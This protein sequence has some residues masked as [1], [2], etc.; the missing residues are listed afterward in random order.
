[1][2]RA[3]GTARRVGIALG[4]TALAVGAA[5]LVRTPQLVE[6]VAQGESRELRPDAEQV[7]RPAPGEGTDLLV[8]ALDGIGRQVL[9]DA[10]RAGELPELAALLGG[11]DGRDLPHAHLHP[12]L[13]SVLPSSTIP[14]WASIFS[15]A[16]PGEHGVVGNEFFLREKRELAAPAPASI[17]DIS[18]ALAIY[19]DAGADQWLHGH[20]VYERLRL[21]EPG[22]R[23]WV[24]LSQFYRGA[25]RL[26]LARRTAIAS[27]LEAYLI[28]TAW[29]EGSE[30]LFATL[31]EEVV[32]TVV[33]ELEERDPPN[34]LTV[35]L[36]GADLFA[37]RS[38]EGPD[39]IP[40]YLREPLDRI[41]GQ[42]RRALDARGA[43]ADRWVVVVSDHGHTEVLEDEHH[44]LGADPDTG[45][46]AVLAGAG[47]R[48][49]PFEWKV[50]DD[51]PFDAVLAYQG[52]MAFV[53]VADRS[54]CGG[55]PC[56]WT[57]PPR[58]EEDVVPVA[59]AFLRATERGEL[60]P[61]LRG[62]IAL[63]LAR[64]PVPPEGPPEPFQVYVGGGRLVPVEEHLTRSPQPGYV[65]LAP[66]LRDL[67]VGPRG[68]RAGDV[69]LIASGTH[70]DDIG[71]R[72]YFSSEY[73][74]WHGS[75]S[76]LDSEVP[77]I[78][79]HPRGSAGEIAAIVRDVLGGDPTQQAVG[80][81]LV[82]L[83]RESV[84]RA[85]TNVRTGR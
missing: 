61:E 23:I 73:R 83:R 39:A 51:E 24:A 48:V 34:V 31:D 58:F 52:G 37:H 60:V 72:Y 85:A 82:R 20:T 57:R 42:L 46:P 27:A 74:S 38:P 80:D 18:P 55:G 3:R 41:I 26:L 2:A 40:G 79:A 25:D 12:D 62:T 19:T 13:L 69:L 63:V 36:P 15:G 81:L 49:R 14:A 75:P 4:A 45:P 44:A 47:F 50:P 43:L 59:E 54:A 71:D 10:L 84:E 16:P 78:V 30:G 21:R 67:A 65:A 66:R 56:D 9:H 11:Q 6:L 70:R 68:G 8:L 1:M 32:E 7:P 76:R 29:K 22:I 5:L 33:R 17:H 77:L 28:D 35:Y 53:Y 64:R